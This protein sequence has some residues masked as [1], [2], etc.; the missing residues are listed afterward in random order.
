M[1]GGDQMALGTYSEQG[2][3]SYNRWYKKPSITGGDFEFDKMDIQFSDINQPYYNKTITKRWNATNFGDIVQPGIYKANSSKIASYSVAPNAISHITM[4]ANYNYSYDNNEIVDYDNIP[5]PNG[6]PSGK[7]EQGNLNSLKDYDANYLKLGTTYDYANRYNISDVDIIGDGGDWVSGHDDKALTYDGNSDTYI[8]IDSEEQVDDDRVAYGGSFSRKTGDLLYSFLL[9][10]DSNTMAEDG[11]YQ[12]WAYWGE[13][14]AN[15]FGRDDDRAYF[16]GSIYYKIN[17]ILPEG[18]N[19]E[20][21]YQMD[22]KVVASWNYDVNDEWETTTRKTLDFYIGPDR[23]DMELIDT[24]NGQGDTTTPEWDTFTK[25]TTHHIEDYVDHYGVG[26]GDYYIRL[27]GQFKGKDVRSSSGWAHPDCHLFIDYIETKVYAKELINIRVYPDETFS[28]AKMYLKFS[29]TDDI[30]VKVKTY[31]PS[32]TWHD[33]QGGNVEWNIGSLEYFDIYGDHKDA[34][35]IRIY[36][37]SIYNRYEYQR[38][39]YTFESDFQGQDTITDNGDQAYEVNLTYMSEYNNIFDLY[40]GNKDDGDWTFLSS[41]DSTSWDTEIISFI[42]TKP[43][44]LR[45]YGRVNSDDYSTDGTLSIMIDQMRIASAFQPFSNVRVLNFTYSVA[46]IDYVENITLSFQSAENFTTSTGNVQWFFDSHQF[47]YWQTEGDTEFFIPEQNLTIEYTIPFEMDY[48]NLSFIIETSSSVWCSSSEVGLQVNDKDVLP[49]APQVGYVDLFDYPEKLKITAEVPQVY[50]QASAH[51]NFHF[52]SELELISRRVLRDE[53]KL[54]SDH[55]IKLNTIKFDSDLDITSIWLNNDP[56]LITT[57]NS[58]IINK[59]MNPGQTF[60]L[61]IYLSEDIYKELS[62][63]FNTLGQGSFQA[64]MW[65]TTNPYFYDDITADQDFFIQLPRDFYL[66]NMDLEFSNLDWL[67]SY[68]SNPD[69]NTHEYNY[70]YPQ[71]GDENVDWLNQYYSTGIN[72]SYLDGYGGSGNEIVYSEDFNSETGEMTHNS[73]PDSYSSTYDV[74][75][76]LIMQNIFPQEFLNNY[77]EGWNLNYDSDYVDASSSSPRCFYETSNIYDISSVNIFG[78]EFAD[79]HFYLTDLYGGY[80]Y[81]Y[82]SDFSS[83]IT[84]YNLGAYGNNNP[85]GIEFADNHFYLTDLY[86]YVY[87][88]NSDFSSLITFYEIGDLGPLGIE[89]ADNHFYLTDLYGGYVYKYN[90][91]FSSLITFYDLGAYGNGNPAGIESLDNYFYVIDYSDGYVYKYNSDFSS[92]ITFYDIRSLYGNNRPYGITIANDYFYVTDNL[93]VTDNYV[94]EYP[95]MANFFSSSFLGVN[96]T[97]YPDYHIENGTLVQTNPNYI[98]DSEGGGD[99]WE[100]EDAMYRRKIDITT[101]STLTDYYY[102]I[103]MSDWSNLPS[104]SD[105]TNFTR[106]YRINSTGKQKE[107]NSQPVDLRWKG[108]NDNGIVIIVND[109]DYCDEWYV[110][111][112]DSNLGNPKYTSDLQYDKNTPISGTY[113][114]YNDNWR[115]EYLEEGR[116]ED[117]ENKAGG[118][119][120]ATTEYFH[121]L[122][123]YNGSRWHYSYVNN[124]WT[125]FTDFPERTL[126]E[127]GCIVITFNQYDNFTE[128]SNCYSLRDSAGNLVNYTLIFKF[129]CSPMIFTEINFTLKASITSAQFQNFRA[130]D[131]SPTNNCYFSH[132]VIDWGGTREI[133][134]WRN[135]ATDWKYGGNDLRY[136]G[137]FDTTTNDGTIAHILPTFNMPIGSS[138]G[139]VRHQGYTYNNWWGKTYETSQTLSAGTYHSDIVIQEDDFTEADGSNDVDGDQP[140]HR[141]SDMLWATKTETLSSY[142]EFKESV[143]NITCTAKLTDL[144]SKDVLLNFS[145]SISFKTNISQVMNISVFNF[146]LGS[147]ELLN[148]SISTVYFTNIYILNNSYLNSTFYSKIKIYGNNFSMSP[149]RLDIKL[150][151]FNYTYFNPNYNTTIKKEFNLSFLNRYDI[152]KYKKIFNIPIKFQYRFTNYTTDY[153]FAYFNETSL[154]N[155]GQWHT[156]TYNYRFNSSLLDSLRFIFN[157]SSGLL[158]IKNMNYTF[159]FECLHKYNFSV[160]DSSFDLS[161]AYNTEYSILGS[162]YNSYDIEWADPFWYQLI[163]IAN[164]DVRINKYDANWNF[165]SQSIQLQDTQAREY[166]HFEWDGSYWYITHT[167]KVYKFN[168]DYTYAGSYCDV[169]TGEISLITYDDNGYFYVCLGNPFPGLILKFNSTWIQIQSIQIGNILGNLG[170]PVKPFISGMTYYNGYLYFTEGWYNHLYIFDTNFNWTGYYYK[171]DFSSDSYN[172]IDI[173]GEKLYLNDNFHV[174][175]KEFNLYTFNFADKNVIYQ[176][177]RLDPTFSLNNLQEI[178]GEWYLNFTLSFTEG[179]DE[180]LSSV[181]WWH[182]NEIDGAGVGVLDSSGNGYTG[183]LI[184]MEDDEWETGKL[185]NCIAFDSNDEYIDFGDNF[186]FNY[187]DPFSIGF[188]AKKPSTI[189]Q[190]IYKYNTGTDRGY[191]FVLSATGDIAWFK[192]SNDGSHYIDVRVSLAGVD[193]NW[194][195]FTVTYDGSNLASGCNIY[196]DGVNQTLTTNSDTLGENTIINTESLQLRGYPFSG[197][198][199]FDEL[200]IHDI[201]LH[202]KDVRVRYNYGLG[203]ENMGSMLYYNF[204]NPINNSLILFRLWIEHEDGW[205]NCYNFNSNNS[206]NI[207]FSLNITQ[208]LLDNGKYQFKDFYFEL[209]IAGNPSNI[210]LGNLILYNFD[211][212]Q[213]NITAFWISDNTVVSHQLFDLYWRGIDPYPSH[214]IINQSFTGFEHVNSHQIYN[215]SFIDNN[216]LEMFSFFNSTPGFYRLNFTFYDTKGNWERWTLNYTVIPMISISAAYENPVFVN[217]NNTFFIHVQSA[218][219]ITQIWYD[220]STDYI[221]EY[222]NSS[223]PLYLYEFT[224]NISHPG[225]T[226]YNVSIKVESSFGDMFYLNISDIYAIERA[227]YFDIYN[228]NQRYWQDSE[229]NTTINLRD[230]LNVP[231]SNKLVNYTLWKHSP[232]QTNYTTITA[233]VVKG[234]YVSGSVADMDYVDNQTFMVE[235]ENIAGWEYIDYNFNLRSDLDLT[236]DYDIYLQFTV[237]GSDLDEC[238]IY[239]GSNLWYSPTLNNEDTF[240]VIADSQ[241]FA[242]NSSIKIRC[243]VHGSTYFNISIDQLKA[244]HNEPFIIENSTLTDINGDFNIYYLLNTSWHEGWYHLNISLNDNIEYT[245]MWETISFEIYPIYRAVNGTEINLRVN[246]FPVINNTYNYGFVAA[247]SF[248]FDITHIGNLTFDLRLNNVTLY[249]EIIYEYDEYI[250]YNF[251]FDQQG[252]YFE[253]ILIQEFNMSYVPNNISLYYFNGLNKDTY[254]YLKSESTLI[255]QDPV[256]KTYNNLDTF[257]I[258]LRYFLENQKRHQIT[259]L[260][261]TDEATVVFSQTFM[262]EK[263]YKF[264]FFRAEVPV[265]EIEEF[266]HLRTGQEI[267]DDDFIKEDNK[268]KF[269][270]P[271][272]TETNDLFTAVIDFDPQWNIDYDIDRFNGT[273]AR[274]I[275]DYSAGVIVDN[276]TLVLD[277]E[278]DGVYIQDWD[279]DDVTQDSKYILKIYDLLFTTA[280]QQIIIEGISE[281]PEADFGNIYPEQS[282]PIIHKDIELDFKYYIKYPLHSTSYFLPI[283]SSWD[284][285]G[286]HYKEKTYYIDDNGYFTTSDDLLGPNIISSYLS[287]K[288]PSVDYIKEDLDGNSLK[289]TI[290]SL[291]NIKHGIYLIKFNSDEKFNLRLVSGVG[292]DCRVKYDDLNN[293]WYIAGLDLEKGKNELELEITYLDTLQVFIVLIP[294][295]AVLLGLGIYYFYKKRKGETIE[296]SRLSEA[297]KI[298][299]RVLSIEYWQGELS[300]AG[301]SLKKGL[302]PKKFKRKQKKKKRKKKEQKRDLTLKNLISKVKSMEILQKEEEDKKKKKP[303]TKQ[304][305]KGLKKIRD[306][307]S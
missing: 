146:D 273:Y 178:M 68:S 93:D 192:L 165:I 154:I 72:G 105:W 284:M 115:V 90:S 121:T 145:I 87:K 306:K 190:G 75:G 123:L 27:R 247:N 81:K 40:Y 41:L 116:L 156:Y 1:C 213:P 207:D 13:H 238:Y 48:L 102:E 227:A 149:F 286:V 60:R 17:N 25:S 307:K 262:A 49:T 12:E 205:S 28:I 208:I 189:S 270:L 100:V 152:D 252:G 30:D 200:S 135:W 83:L 43:P 264:W 303:L 132:E 56:Y 185:G 133:K 114:I 183:T 32:Q 194:H 295:F 163:K 243:I 225:V 33:G 136:T 155:D 19:V 231:M 299:K 219:S 167:D 125:G 107:I 296:I 179:I 211:S 22:I 67:P 129:T 59:W 126:V 248:N 290:K 110:Y 69:H 216:T 151:T 137:K 182:L 101:T 20:D 86:G 95:I 66:K 55:K 74:N 298:I 38:L 10:G 235:S 176:Y 158:E 99:V 139:Y 78:I 242:T 294:I 170:L 15:G 108:D 245:S 206:F 237:N 35:S 45:I 161:D 85:T 57:N 256:G 278:A 18:W 157:I 301:S 14:D 289:I 280:T 36:E 120:H 80:V 58:V 162:Q 196:I 173:K 130:G 159:I 181:G 187:N 288:G 226:T 195:Y 8:Q 109:T 180:R 7:V 118:S 224:F 300:E 98:I 52:E 94:Y 71:Y 282:T 177:F 217:K 16:D 191:F 287:F 218:Y 246:G 269:S 175:V 302:V 113:E 271:N 164:N 103:N 91:D 221:L 144:F 184:N 166:S 279:N 62:Y 232:I 23:D 65:G 73:Y 138:N 233:T 201:E 117:F 140:A 147:W 199:Y 240:S 198:H 11:S 2:S 50:F 272:K 6:G 172:G 64:N 171:M 267:D 53:F 174:K 255:P 305:G 51:I 258:Q 214:I 54:V 241:Q 204:T 5:N 4:N 134:T 142:E 193:S 285:D 202:E 251:E 9:G 153:T 3:G 203:T 92:L 304:I 34:F 253:N 148:S 77:Y 274:I 266:T 223:Y 230:F 44:D 220:N 70:D 234:D 63:F 141:R 131:P 84:S 24:K 275:I 122:Q 47:W 42:Y 212:T 127:N 209:Y 79:N 276:V 124:G 31:T 89:F 283:K 297:V 263:D 254:T 222:D 249:I 293:I 229:I 168:S 104:N 37:C 291:Y 96:E 260:P 186:G 188:W 119:Y 277:L 244:V 265:N 88:Y 111:Y 29:S 143:L 210:S 215:I 281:I 261:R 21:Y 128:S 239:G 268:Y 106:V 46:S 257:N 292:E 250:D 26:D 76:D 150:I 61:D 39:E 82:N 197:A 112:G 228:L 160:I 259:E 97:S 236:E 169:G